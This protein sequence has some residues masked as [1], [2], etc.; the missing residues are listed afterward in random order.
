MGTEW[1]ALQD[2]QRTGMVMDAIRQLE[3]RKFT[4]MIE[5]EMIV[6]ALSGKD[7]VADA[8]T[9]QDGEATIKSHDQVIAEYDARITAV[10]AAFPLVA[11]EETTP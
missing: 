3:I 1:H 9:V 8:T 7:P 10:L 2:D 4:H 6:G 11:A 5:R